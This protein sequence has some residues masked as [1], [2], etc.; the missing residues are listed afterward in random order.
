MSQPRPIRC[1][2]YTRKSTEE[3]LDQAFNSLDAQREACLAYVKSQLGEGWVLHP[4]HYDDGGFS[5]GN[6][7]RPAL[8]RL[9]QDIDEGRID[10][11]VVYKIDRLTRSLADF[12]KIV[13]RFEKRGVTFVSVTQSFNTTT[14]MGRLTLN[15]LLSFAQFEREVTAER[16]RDKFAASRA[17]G[18]FMGGNPPLGYEARDRRLV[19]NE[20]EAEHVR[21]IFRRYLELRSIAELARELDAKGIQTKAWVST[22]EKSCG[23]IG[24]YVGP[25]R[26]LLRN[27]V[28]IGLT[29]H[30]GKS[31]P[32]QHQAIVDPSL[33]DKVQAT[34]DAGSRRARRRRTVESSALLTGI[35]FDERANRMTPQWN[36][37]RSD[38]PRGYYVCQAI[39]QRRR[40][41]AGAQPRIPAALIEDLVLGC[42]TA[43]GM[44]DAAGPKASRQGDRLEKEERL[45]LSLAIREVVQRVVITGTHTLIELKP[46]H[47]PL[48]DRRLP[49]GTQVRTLPACTEVC[50]PGRLARHGGVRRIE[51]WTKQDWSG[52]ARANT[53]LTHT[54]VR[55]HIWREAIEQGKAGTLDELARAAALDRRRIRETIRLSTLAPDI[56]AAI[57][58]GRQPASLTLE[59][60]LE[61]GPPLSW[62]EQRRMLG[63]TG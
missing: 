49:T 1:A 44:K 47:A 27:R 63:V 21:F 13:E 16:I 59:R 9:L 26:Y 10:C 31:Y 37:G 52:S 28:Y 23:G 24:W 17:R 25:L 58:D 15:V 48:D 45:R 61:A 3:G 40:E 35:I 8:G 53:P 2:I 41:L 38:V 12:A 11:V 22:R 32:G 7:E 5:G 39:M 33:F 42:L 19:V 4:P 46:G 56:Q 50:I 57:L 34:L 30:K 18:I 6:M 20:V 54:L 14:S 51:N 43:L 62:A 29:L 60:I 36:L 55:A